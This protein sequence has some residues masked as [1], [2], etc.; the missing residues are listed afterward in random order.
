MLK[1]FINI[2]SKILKYENNEINNKIYSK[3]F[4]KNYKFL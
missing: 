4:S 1:L 2:D 3:N